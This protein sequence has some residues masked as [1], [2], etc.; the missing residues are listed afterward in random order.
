MLLMR[1]SDALARRAIPS[2][3]VG[4]LSSRSLLGLIFGGHAI[5]LGVILFFPGPAPIGTQHLVAR[6][7]LWRRPFNH[8]PTIVSVLPTV[9]RLPPIG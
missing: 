6:T 9:P 5:L 1:G 3:N 4:W 2:R 7:I 8:L